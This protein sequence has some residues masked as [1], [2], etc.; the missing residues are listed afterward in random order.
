MFRG[1]IPFDVSKIGMYSWTRAA[2]IRGFFETFD[3][4][5][6]AKLG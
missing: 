2:R 6:H 5:D 4:R 3:A 1:L